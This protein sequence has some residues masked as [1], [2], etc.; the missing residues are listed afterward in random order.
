MAVSRRLRFIHGQLAWMTVGVV[1]L[2]ALDSLAPESFFVVSLIG[3][4]VVFEL[5][6]P[7]NVTPRWRAR[8]RWILLVGLAGFAYVVVERILEILPEGVV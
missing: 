5:T 8:L 3:F 7:V 4:L 1:L 6:A 2:V